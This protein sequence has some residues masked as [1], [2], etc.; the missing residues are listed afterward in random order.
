MF[1]L[2][3]S[4]YPGISAMAENSEE[5]KA[6]EALFV[7]NT[8]TPEQA[9]A[10]HNVRSRIGSFVLTVVYCTLPQL[11]VTVSYCNCILL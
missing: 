6:L 7:A 5:R 10:G 1:K 3:H 2:K 11:T 8:A 9:D 4:T